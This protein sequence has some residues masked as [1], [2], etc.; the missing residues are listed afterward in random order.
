MGTLQ[1]KTIKNNQYIVNGGNKAF[2]DGDNSISESSN[3]KRILK[4]ISKLNDSFFE[5]LKDY[6][7]EEALHPDSERSK[8][9]FHECE[10][11]NRESQKLL[12]LL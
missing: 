5:R 11:L 8:Q 2:L 3:R 10:A 12:D 1:Y 7:I 6:D 4:T 9:L